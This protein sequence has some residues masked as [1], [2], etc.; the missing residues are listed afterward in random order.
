MT[1]N[2]TPHLTHEQLCDLILACS[3]HPLSSDFAVLED[4][5]RADRP[6]L[7]RAVF[8]DSANVQPLSG[9]LA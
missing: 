6:M 3:P 8:P 9:L 2:L 1:S 7:D 4:H 5:L